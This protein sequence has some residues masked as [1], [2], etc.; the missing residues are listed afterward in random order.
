MKQGNA[1]RLVST[2]DLSREEWLQ[3]RNR[4]LGSS[5]AAAAI[6][7]SPYKSPLELWLEKTGRSC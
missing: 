3:I 7:L 1:I 2:R 6:G 5:D 4:G